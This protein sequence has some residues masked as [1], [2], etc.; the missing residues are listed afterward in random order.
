MAYSPLV[1][2][3]LSGASLRQLSHWRSGETPLMRPAKHVRGGRVGYSFAD[4]VAL[5]TV[6][7]LRGR[8][9]PLQRVRKAVVALRGMGEDEHLSRYKLIAVGKDVVWREDA[10]QAVAL[11]G[12]PRNYVIAEMVDILAGFDNMRG[13]KVVPLRTP[14]PGVNVDPD[15]RSGYPV[16]A[17]TRVPYDLVSSLL[18]DGLAPAEIADVYPSVSAKAAVGAQKFARIVD[19]YRDQPHAA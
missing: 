19:A 12:Q 1:A 8:D 15:V 5:R 7:Y 4:V 16:I 13:S 10:E 11:T 6:V 9:V 14:V 18:D 2:A 17:G 3:A